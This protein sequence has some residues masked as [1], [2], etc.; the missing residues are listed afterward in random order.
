MIRRPMNTRSFFRTV[1]LCAVVTGATFAQDAPAPSSPDPDK[2]VLNNGDVITGT[3][4]SMADGKVTIKSSLLDTVTVPM[5]SIK[6]MTTAA[7]VALETK[8]NEL[9]QRR[10]TGIEGGNLRLEGVTDPLALGDLTRINPPPKKDPEWNGSLKLNG[11][12][13]DGNTDRRSAGLLFDAVHLSER[14][15]ITV[16]SSWDYAENKTN[17]TGVNQWVLAQRRTGGGLKYDFFLGKKLYLLA[18]TRVLSD[19]RANLSLRYSVGGGLGYTWVEDSNTT[20]LTEC[21]LAY[22]KEDYRTAAPS[23]DYLSVRVAYRLSHKFSD[24]FKFVH[25]AEA[26]PSTQN[27]N[28]VYAQVVTEVVGNFT[29]S[30]IAAV[31]HILDYDNTPA[32]GNVRTDN[33]VL[34]SVGWSF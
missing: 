28:D 30:M 3:I 11:A 27:A 7:Q 16:D 22:L 18:Q 26:Y 15:R 21:G 8:S 32:P 25:R 1:A 14:D 24:K 9:R 34:L 29:D 17:I 2:I 19:T 23:T 6:D 12:Y 33:R 4:V 31:S 13:V 20:F 5:S 10:I